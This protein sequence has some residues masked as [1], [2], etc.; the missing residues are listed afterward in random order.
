VEGEG[1]ISPLAL[2]A[3]KSHNSFS[4]RKLRRWSESD[5]LSLETASILLI[6]PHNTSQHYPYKHK[7]CASTFADVFAEC[8]MRSLDQL[9]VMD[10]S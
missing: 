2:R 5:F 10:T 8:D 3:K 1:R 4:N 6:R 7:H 9:F